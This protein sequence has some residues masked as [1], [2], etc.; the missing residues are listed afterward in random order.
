M[1]LHWSP[2]SPFVRKVMIVAHEQGL[3]DR[4]ECV[5]TVAETTEP[6]ERLMADNPLNKIPTL[7][8]DDGTVLHDSRVICEYLDGLGSGAQLFPPNGMPRWQALR[9]QALGDG[10]LDFL[11][12]WRQERLRPEKL[13]SEPY[14]RAYGIKLTR[15]LDRLEAEADAAVPTSFNIGDVAVGCALAYLDFRFADIDWRATRPRLVA[16]RE[17]FD[18]RASAKATAII[19]DSATAAP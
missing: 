13:R 4:I 2:K 1:K 9:R 17:T 12:V 10:L 3:L 7:V 8:L 14:L 11:L 16:W 15:T 5:R 6:S 18:A 19:D